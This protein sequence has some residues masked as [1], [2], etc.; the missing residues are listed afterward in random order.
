MGDIIVTKHIFTGV[1][2]A[3]G[4]ARRMQGQDKGL[5]ELG[6]SPMIQYV[7]DALSLQVGTLIINANRNQEIYRHYGYPVVQDEL[8]GYCG[9]LAGMASC[10][11]LA[12]TPFMVTSPCDS[13]FIPRNL[14]ERL[15]L[16]LVRED[17]DISVAHN[18]ERIQPVMALMKTSLL[19]SMIE[20]LHSGNRKIDT[21]YEQHS[22]TV[23]DFSD[24]PDT[25]LNINT[26]EDLENIE[27]RLKDYGR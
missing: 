20:Y 10:M 27:S 25:F 7:L 5:V 17:A 8:D 16:Q 9:P 15:Y 24:V 14:V 6:G 23:T 26:R 4:Q 21:W 12:T 19:D 11:R 18:G 2:L 1:I 3:G 22:L 13:P